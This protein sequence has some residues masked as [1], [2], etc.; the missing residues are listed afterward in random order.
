MLFSEVAR[1]VKQLLSSE[2]FWVV[3]YVAAFILATNLVVAKADQKVETVADRWLAAREVASNPSSQ[4]VLAMA[5]GAGA[6]TTKRMLQQLHVI[7]ARKEYHAE[8]LKYFLA[9]YYMALSIAPAAAIIAAAMLL[10]I[11]KSG[12]DAANTFTKTTF[13]VATGVATF[14]GPFPNLFKQEANAEENGRLYVAYSNLEQSM[15]TYLA[16]GPVASDSTSSPAWITR[17]FDERMASLN[18]VAVGFD[19]SQV[20]DAKG[21]FGIQ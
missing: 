8:L 7:R 14:F 15:L 21:A 5:L 17:T 3:T 11:S 1:I 19:A 6:P 4:P 10:L 9:R 12:W 2:K 18:A 20:P 16:T 13:L